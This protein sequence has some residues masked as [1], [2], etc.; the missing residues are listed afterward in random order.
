MNSH[1][2]RKSKRKEK[3]KLCPN[4]GLPGP[5]WIQHPYSDDNL[6]SMFGDTG[7]WTCPKLYGPDGRR[8]NTVDETLTL[9]STYAFMSALSSLITAL[10]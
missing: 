1:Q 8:L 9:G 4:C 6:A 5:H 10:K 3:N 2:R 7:F